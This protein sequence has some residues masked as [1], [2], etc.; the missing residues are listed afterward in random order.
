MWLQVSICE[1][2]LFQLDL[3]VGKYEKSTSDG[4]ALTTFLT[5]LRN[6]QNSK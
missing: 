4:M 6:G 2:I 5:G 3:V 1:K